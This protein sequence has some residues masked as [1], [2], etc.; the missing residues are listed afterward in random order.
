MHWYDVHLEA[1][2]T[3]ENNAQ[4][5]VVLPKE[6]AGGRLAKRFGGRRS[7]DN[8][9]VEAGVCDILSR[10]RLVHMAT[11]PNAPGKLTILAVYQ[12]PDGVN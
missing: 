12:S 10:K 5:N 2:G 6:G 3:S 8:L 11:T 7:R 1:K 4:H 9:L